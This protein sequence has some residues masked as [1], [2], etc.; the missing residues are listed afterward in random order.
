MVT[1]LS[2]ILIGGPWLIS[3]PI[4]TLVIRLGVGRITGVLDSLD[5][6]CH[7]CIAFDVCLPNLVIGACVGD[8]VYSAERFFN[9]LFTVSARH[10]FDTECRHTSL[11]V[12][13]PYAGFSC[14][15]LVG[16]VESPEPTEFSRRPHTTKVV[17]TNINHRIVVLPSCHA[18]RCFSDGYVP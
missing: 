12:L 15:L 6:F 9:G 4:Y 2:A 18:C 3:Q 13:L 14:D 8:T 5:Q 16:T 7:I 11:Y 10:P 17:G 1:V